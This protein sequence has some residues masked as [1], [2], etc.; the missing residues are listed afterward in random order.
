MVWAATAPPPPPLPLLAVGTAPTV[1][2]EA[3]IGW[4]GWAKKP[5]ETDGGVEPNLRGEGEAKMGLVVVPPE[6]A[7]GVMPSGGVAVGAT[8]PPPSVFGGE[9]M[10]A[11]D[12]R[13]SGLDVPRLDAPRLDAP[14]LDGPGKRALGKVGLPS[15]GETPKEA[16]G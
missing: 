5:A 15:R 12:D 16:P 8:K 3:P 11:P 4:T 7:S 6:R 13:S 2:S 10:P 9:P 14:R 1:V